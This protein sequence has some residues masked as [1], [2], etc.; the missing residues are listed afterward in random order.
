MLKLAIT[1]FHK[2]Q[3]PLIKVLWEKK[4]NSM[5]LLLFYIHE[6]MLLF[7]GVSTD[8]TNRPNSKKLEVNF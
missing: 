4:Q 8:S 1:E 3:Q 6:K 7:A 5:L 2:S